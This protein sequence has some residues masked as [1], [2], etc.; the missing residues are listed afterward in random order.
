MMCDRLK[1]IA[2]TLDMCLFSHCDA[3]ATKQC[4]MQNCFLP[5]WSATRAANCDMRKY[6]PQ[7]V[8]MKDV[9]SVSVAH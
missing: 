7:K 4:R 8:D 3:F 2:A 9:F 5:N 1:P 6:Q